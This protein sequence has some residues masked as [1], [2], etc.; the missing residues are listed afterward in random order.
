MR[1]VRRSARHHP[2]QA[3]NIEGAG[4]SAPGDLLRHAPVAGVM[5]LDAALQQQPPPQPEALAP[6]VDGRASN[7]QQPAAEAQDEPAGPA[8]AAAGNDADGTAADDESGGDSSAPLDA[9]PPA[10]QPSQGVS[11]LAWT[12][13]PRT[14]HAPLRPPERHRVGTHSPPCVLRISQMAACKPAW[15][16]QLP[17]SPLPPLSAVRYLVRQAS[18]KRSDPPNGA[19]NVR[20]WLSGPLSVR[21]LA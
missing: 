10:P 9:T 7:G 18:A 13:H 3:A 4:P 21:G 17:P 11:S 8:D 16:P 1:S 5:V 12:R 6:V 15:M 14:A 19:R 20:A 2:Y